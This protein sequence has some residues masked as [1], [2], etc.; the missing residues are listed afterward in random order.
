[1]KHWS[2]IAPLLQGPALAAVV[3]VAACSGPLSSG[4]T[5]PSTTAAAASPSPAPRT[6]SPSPLTAS[7]SLS[8]A[9]LPA[10]GAL[11]PGTY[12]TLF[13]GYRWTVTV[14][15]QGWGSGD[16]PDQTIFIG[17]GSET[18]PQYFAGLISYGDVDD[19][20]SDACQ[21][22]GAD[23]YP[24]PTVDDFA[25]ALAAIKGFETTAPVA[26]DVSGYHGKMVR[27]TVPSDVNF[28]TCDA[29]EYH[30]FSER[31]DYDPGQVEEVRLID[32]DGVRYLFFTVVQVGTPADVLSELEQMVNSLEIEPA[33]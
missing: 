20:V 12:T 32:L 23:V 11:E 18:D 9:T 17:K 22:Q 4:T 31:S 10:G 30:S 14:S 25:S 24:G 16:E 29:G 13:H 1:M 5:A 33:S 2:R 21:W 28:A 6:A 8:A 26:V 19:L 15:G 27:L 3:V 7:P